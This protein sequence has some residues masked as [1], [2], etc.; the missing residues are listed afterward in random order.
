MALPE[1]ITFQTYMSTIVSLVAITVSSVTLGW[2]IY[3]DAI[4]KPKFRMSIGVRHI[5][6]AGQPSDGPH[7][8]LEALNVGPIPNR[9]GV[10]FARKNWVKRR[11]TDRAN[12]H[13]FI[14]PNFGHWA[15]TQSA[16]RIEVGDLQRLSFRMS[17]S[18]AF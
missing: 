10:P 4:R 6:R 2:T 9:I 5:V 7:I 3:K 15:T 8:F 13:I 16:A 11:I 12:G 18:L 17:R 14:Y 1:P